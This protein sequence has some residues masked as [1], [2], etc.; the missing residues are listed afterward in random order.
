MQS[1]KYVHEL[2]WLS[3]VK[4][5]HWPWS[6]SFRFNIFKLLFLN[7]HWA[8]WSQISCGASSGWRNES[9]CKWSKSHDQDGRHVHIWGKNL[10]KN[11]SMEP[12]GQW[13]WNLVCSIEYY[14][15]Y[16]N[17]APVLT[18]TYFTARSNLVP[19]TF[20]W[21]KVKGFFRNYC[22]LWYQSW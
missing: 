21:E 12:K 9:V 15:I 8:D 2:I 20:V 6:K 3:K 10:K 4:V 14:Q 5:I 1:I 7:N 18:L 22:S 17:D 16:S 19:C 11:S 13:P